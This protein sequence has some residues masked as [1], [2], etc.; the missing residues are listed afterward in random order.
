M[1]PLPPADLDHVLERT[2]PLWEALRGR[3]IFITGGTG[4]F[5]KWL[6]GTFEHANRALTLGA[7]A[8][9]LSRQA[10]A[11]REGVD[12]ITGDVRAFDFPAGEFSHIIHAATT[13]SAPVP[14]EEMR[15]TILEGTERVLDFAAHCGAE[16]LLFT[17]SG[18]VYGP[19]PPEVTHLAETFPANP[20]TPYGIGKLAAEGLCFGSGIPS[21]VAR[22]FA[23]AGAHLPIDQHFAIGNFVRDA[24]TGGP[25]RVNGDG[26][27]LRSYLDAADL[28]AW[29]WTLLLRGPSGGVFNVGSDHA[30]SIAELADRVATAA[31]DLRVQVLGTPSGEAPARYVPDISLAR[32]VLGLNVWI[33]LDTAIRRMLAWHSV[34]Q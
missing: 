14:A 3:R 28:A 1:K 7:E 4:F 22:C 23:F 27:P 15:S 30:L 10:H 20:I 26:A 5:G 9:V 24:L 17:S 16:K 19:Q 2:R 33:D 6:L 18:A 12:F 11:S 21:S 13:S 8:V 32:S 25:V 31:G 34:Q 29:L